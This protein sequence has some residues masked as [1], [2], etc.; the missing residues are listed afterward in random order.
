MNLNSVRISYVSILDLHNFPL[1]LSFIKFFLCPPPLLHL[2]FT[3]IY[4]II[5]LYLLSVSVFLSFSVVYMHSMFG[6]GGYVLTHRMEGTVRERCPR[7]LDTAGRLIALGRTCV[8]GR[9]GLRKG[10]QC[11][12]TSSNYLLSNYSAP[13]FLLGARILDGRHLICI[14][15]SLRKRGSD[16]SRGWRWKGSL[17]SNQVFYGEP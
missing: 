3:T 8:L 1:L 4:K 11:K 10:R 6:V 15:G 13:G 5:V 12:H 2:N 14:C 7:L 9:P 17:N 16:I